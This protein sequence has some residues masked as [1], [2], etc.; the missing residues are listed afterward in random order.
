MSTSFVRMPPLTTRCSR[1]RESGHGGGSRATEKAG[2]DTGCR[3]D[4]K[5]SEAPQL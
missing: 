4:T 2:D 1:Q 5:R 3:R